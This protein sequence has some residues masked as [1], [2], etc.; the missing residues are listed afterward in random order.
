MKRKLEA[1]RTYMVC[2]RPGSSLV[3]KPSTGLQAVLEQAIQEGP[4]SMTTIISQ[5][6]GA[7]RV[8][9]EVVWAV[10]QLHGQ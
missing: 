7:G 8:L 5:K 4:M 1:Q 2:P 3:V 9:R 10:E 6:L